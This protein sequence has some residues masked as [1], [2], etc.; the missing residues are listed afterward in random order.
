MHGTDAA[1]HEHGRTRDKHARGDEHADIDSDGGRNA[2]SS[3][4]AH[5]RRNA[6]NNG[7][8]H[9]R[10]RQLRSGG[11]LTHSAAARGSCVS[12]YFGM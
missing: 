1:S 9:C 2:D 7:Y 12:Y 11:L 10:L 3:R 6:D 5:G 8:Q 4:N